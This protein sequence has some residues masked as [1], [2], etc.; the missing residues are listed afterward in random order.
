METEKNLEEHHE[1]DNLKELNI[2]NIDNSIKTVFK[3]Y[4]KNDVK[5]YI[6]NLLHAHSEEMQSLN[7][8]A[9]SLKTQNASLKGDLSKAV[10]KYNTLVQKMEDPEKEFREER[11][12][13]QNKITELETTITKNKADFDEIETI[14]KRNESLNASL[15]NKDDIISSQEGKI[16]ELNDRIHIL[17]MAASEKE[18]AFS[19]SEREKDAALKIKAE[20]VSTLTEKNASLMKIMNEGELSELR[21]E[22]KKVNTELEKLSSIRESEEKELALLQTANKDLSK[23]NTEFI[24]KIEDL[25]K[26]NGRLN[27]E[28]TRL[29]GYRTLLENE[30]KELY[31][32]NI[33][34]SEALFDEKMKH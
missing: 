15:K 10:E 31:E 14:K 33:A 6:A 9:E 11:K 2:L 30:L 28:I 3:G 16:N 23:K 20:E 29:T 13:L 19:K 25:S 24:K 1:E 12:E 7:G 34:L 27:D 4:D 17:T 5:Q 21:I 32:K 22:L 18:A 8:V 26:E